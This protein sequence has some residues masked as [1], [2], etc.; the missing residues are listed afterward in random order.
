MA[1]ARKKTHHNFDATVFSRSL[2]V[3]ERIGRGFDWSVT[4]S[5]KCIYGFVLLRRKKKKFTA[6]QIHFTGGSSVAG[7]WEHEGWG[8]CVSEALPSSM[9]LLALTTL[10]LNP[11]SPA[12]FSFLFSFFFPFW[13]CLN[14]FLSSF[15]FVD[16]FGYLTLYNCIHVYT[17]G[18]DMTLVPS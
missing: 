14:L 17:A 6:S 16:C 11:H 8:V 15:L 7:L 9:Y 1:Y 10:P 4:Y 2:N 13:F 3:P 18:G 5:I 12:N